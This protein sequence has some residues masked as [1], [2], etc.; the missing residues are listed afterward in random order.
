MP[1]ARPSSTTATSGTASAD[2]QRTTEEDGAVLAGHHAANLTDSGR[3]RRRKDRARGRQGVGFRSR[4]ARGKERT[5]AMDQMAEEGGDLIRIGQHW[6]SPQP[7]PGSSDG[8]SLGL[9][10]RWPLGR[11]PLSATRPAVRMG[12][13]RGNAGSAGLPTR[14]PQPSPAFAVG[15]E[16]EGGL[17]DSR[18]S[19]AQI[20]YIYISVQLEIDVLFNLIPIYFRSR[21]KCRLKGVM[22]Y[23]R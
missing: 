1:S 19:Q 18:A 17:T 10:L 3:R 11:P 4:G 9:S 6:I 14:L 2:P 8:S 12:P 20:L 22:L 5:G 13:N 7:R 16:G 21:I 23:D 15:K